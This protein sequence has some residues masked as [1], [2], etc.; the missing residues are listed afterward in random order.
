MHPILFH[1]G[2]LPIHTYGFMIAVGFL[3]AVSVIRAERLLCPGFAEFCCLAPRVDGRTRAQHNLLRVFEMRCFAEAAV[4]YAVPCSA[5]PT[6]PQPPP[7]QR[8]LRCLR[9]RPAF[10]W[11]TGIARS[12]S[13]RPRA[14]LL[15]FALPPPPFA[16][17]ASASGAPRRHRETRGA[18]H[19]TL[20]PSPMSCATRGRCPSTFL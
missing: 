20:S 15:P 12:T 4:S 17:G 16:G 14:S 18:R 8:G 1:L 3:V 5:Y 19:L 6:L 9:L 11:C 10:C 7:S 2:P 13:P